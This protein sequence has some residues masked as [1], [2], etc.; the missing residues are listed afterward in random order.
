MKVSII[1]AVA[2]NGVIGRKGKIPWH[3]PEDLKRF[4]KITTG[5]HIIMGRKTY[6]S[7]GR[8]LPNRTNIVITRNK[9]YKAKGIKTVS[10]LNEALKIAKKEGEKEAMIVGG[11]QIYKEAL[12]FADKIYLTKIHHKFSGD[13]YFPK[14]SLLKWKKVYSKK[15]PKSSK[16]KYSYTFSILK[17]QGKEK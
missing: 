14:I 9:D 16:N 8:P 11:A 6:E 5:H 10:S 2:E 12:P 13:A 3:I 17:A 1:A 15:Y 7:I 4:K